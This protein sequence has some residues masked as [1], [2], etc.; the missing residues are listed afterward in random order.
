MQLL[1]PAG[2]SPSQAAGPLFVMGCIELFFLF[3]VAAWF[4]ARGNKWRERK[5]LARGYL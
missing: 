5:S 1:A 4:G 3:F 2:M